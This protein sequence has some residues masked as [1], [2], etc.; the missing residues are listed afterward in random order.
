MLYI[1]MTLL[2]YTSKSTH[3]RRSGVELTVLRKNGQV[4]VSELIVPETGKGYNQ[5]PGFNENLVKK[6]GEGEKIW[7]IDRPTD[8]P[9]YRLIDLSKYLMV[10]SD[11][12]SVPGTVS[13]IT[14]QLC[15]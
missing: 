3:C 11:D 15:Y 7:S 9:I 10:W 1:A 6:E 8:R 4:N 14:D 2:R 5:G 12:T 13:L